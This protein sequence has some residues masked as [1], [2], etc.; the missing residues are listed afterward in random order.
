MISG[1]RTSSEGEPLSTDYHA[2]ELRQLLL[3]EVLLFYFFEDPW[4]SVKELFDVL[5]EGDFLNILF[6]ALLDVC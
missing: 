3:G 2:D 4:N 6:L 1:R 5:H